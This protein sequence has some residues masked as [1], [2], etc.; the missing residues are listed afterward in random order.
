MILALLLQHTVQATLDLGN[1]GVKVSPS[2][3]GLMTEEINYSYDGGLYA[4]LI[5][6]RAFLDDTKQPRHWSAAGDGSTITLEKAG[7][8]T[9]RPFSLKVKGAAANEGFWGFPIRSNNSYRLSLYV[10]ADSKTNLIASLESRDGSKVYAKTQVSGVDS[11]WRKVS[12]V[13]KAGSVSASTADA[14]FVL[15]ATGSETFSLAQVSLFP[16]TYNKNKTVFRSDLVEKMQAL[17]PTFLRFPGGNYLEGNTLKDYFPWEKTLGP[18]EDRPGHMSPWGYRS[19]DGMG[20]AEFLQWCEAINSKPVLGVYAGYALNGDVIKPGPELDKFVQYALDEIE[21]IVGAPT[22]K[23]G[24]QRVR[25]GHPKPYPLEYV[26]IGNEDGFDKSGSYPARYAVFYRAIKSKYPQLSIIS[27]TGGTDWLGMKYPIKDSPLEVVDEHYYSTAWEMMTMANKYDSF[28]RKGPKVFVGEWAAHT[29]PAPWEAGAKG[30]T[31]DMRSA[32]GDAAF[33]TG[34]ER[35]SDHVVMSCYAPLFVRVDPGGMQ[36]KL[37][38]VGYNTL[39]TF[40]S[41]SYYAQTMFAQNLGDRV[42]PLSLSGVA[43]QQEGGKTL[44]GCFASATIDSKTGTVFIK[45]VNALDSE[46]TFNFNTKGGSLA[47]TGTLTTITGP[48]DAVN[49]IAEPKKI[50]PSTKKVAVG[51]LGL[52]I[53]V[54][55]NSVNVFQIKSVR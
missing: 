22:T 46:Q 28:D 23:W 52:S 50:F 18:I 37:N 9:A 20:L 43:T 49:S 26:E 13:L 16:P 45:L 8:T 21:Y 1:P 30:P 48:N 54:P 33:M 19:T 29:G 40:G 6:N 31:S 25:D 39:D 12:A 55:G 10:K 14:R 24:A 32:I 41:P 34:M 47:A 53:K 44:P 17:K 42:L 27:S 38:L 7:P 36:W 51:S 15:R 3:Y 11:A 35:N 4:E 2:L 5:R